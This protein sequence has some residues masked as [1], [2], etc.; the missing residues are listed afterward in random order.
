MVCGISVCKKKELLTLHKHLDS[1]LV[2]GG[3]HVAQLFCF[4]VLC[5]F[6]VYVLVLCLFLNIA[7]AGVIWYFEPHGKLTP[8]SHMT[9]ALFILHCPFCSL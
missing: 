1:P 2:F 6:V 5:I 9:P 8:R 3:V 4:S 7:S